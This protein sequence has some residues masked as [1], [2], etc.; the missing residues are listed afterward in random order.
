MKRS[1]IVQISA[2]PFA[3]LV[4][5]A[6]EARSDEV[7]LAQAR[8]HRLQTVCDQGLANLDRTLTGASDVEWRDAIGAWRERHADT[9]ADLHELERWIAEH[10]PAAE[11]SR[12]DEPPVSADTSA[13]VRPAL[14]EARRLRLEMAQ[15][16]YQ[17]RK[18]S[19]IERRNA[20]HAWMEKNVSRLAANAAQLRAVLGAQNPPL[21]IPT[22]PVLP[23]ELE[24]EVC[25]RLVD[26]AALNVELANL[27]NQLRDASPAERRDALGDWHHSRE[28]RLRATNQ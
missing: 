23:P 7:E 12:P 1:F 25:R 19:A 15:V 28:Q 2:W 3:L 26:R 4:L 13:A 24:P 14:E 9:L 11:A 16:Q 5:F 6:V 21:I 8:L 17:W 18:A 27:S 22:T 20:S 10:A